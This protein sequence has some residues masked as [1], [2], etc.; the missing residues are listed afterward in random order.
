MFSAADPD[1]L[2]AISGMGMAS[3]VAIKI[4]MAAAEMAARHQ[5]IGK[6]ILSSGEAVINYCRI[7][8]ARASVE[9]LRLLWLDCHNRLI[10]DE[11]QQ[12][13]TIDQAPVYPREIVKKALMRKATAVILVHNHPSGDPKPS[14]ADIAVSKLLVQA[15]DPIGV[16]L[17]D[18]LIISVSGYCS[19]R[20]MG[21]I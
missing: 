10:A 15:L 11:V 14:Q 16:R 8:M 20:N 6:T 1:E 3:V 7:A 2:A 9:Q 12:Q 13:G 4:P 18:H 19:L 5:A 21:L 17:H